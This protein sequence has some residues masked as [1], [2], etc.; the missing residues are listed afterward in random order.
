MLVKCRGSGIHGIGVLR[1]SN[2][3]SQKML[4]QP[5]LDRGRIEHFPTSILFNAQHY[6]QVSVRDTTYP[7]SVTL[8][9]VSLSVFQLSGVDGVTARSGVETNPL[10]P[11]IFLLRSSCCKFENRIY[12]G[13]FVIRAVA[14]PLITT[15]GPSA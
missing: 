13:Q 2:T 6:L 12:M 4:G 9:P 5:K 8:F 1:T 7:H 3:P 14:Y 10:T 15:E 11:I